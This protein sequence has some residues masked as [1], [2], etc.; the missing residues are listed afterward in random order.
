MKNYIENGQ[1]LKKDMSERRSE[2]YIKQKASKLRSELFL[3]Q[4]V[5]SSIAHLQEVFRVDVKVLKDNEIATR[6]IDLPKELKKMD[7]VLNML[8]SLLKSSNQWLK[9]K[10][11]T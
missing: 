5:K 10:Q 1:S 2:A 11:T 7:E 4:E 6:K 9:T 8:H 3:G